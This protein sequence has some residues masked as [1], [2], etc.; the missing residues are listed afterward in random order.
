MKHCLFGNTSVEECWGCPCRLAEGGPDDEDEMEDCLQDDS[1]RDLE[2]A[3]D[4]ALDYD[5]GEEE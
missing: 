2:D 4:D 3:V 5:Y 1:C